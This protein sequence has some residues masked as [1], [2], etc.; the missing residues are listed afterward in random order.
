MRSALINT[1]A[2]FPFAQS[3][4]VLPLLNNTK[5]RT[6]CA[7]V[8]L[9]GLNR[10]GSIDRTINQLLR[11]LAQKAPE[12]CLTIDNGQFFFQPNT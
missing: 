11:T 1:C 6:R 9:T 8:Q 7:V 4:E 10:K 2:L 5:K 3:S 12:V